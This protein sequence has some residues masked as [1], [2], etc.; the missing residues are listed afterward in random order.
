MMHVINQSVGLRHAR[1]E[2]GGLRWQ[3]AASKMTMLANS[4]G[5]RWGLMGQATGMDTCMV[6]ANIRVCV[7]DVL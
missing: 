1:D 5:V 2:L 6:D 3:L 4:R 7:F